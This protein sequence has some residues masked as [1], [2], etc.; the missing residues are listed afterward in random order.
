MPWDFLELQL[1]PRPQK[2]FPMEEMAASENRLESYSCW[3]PSASQSHPSLNSVQ[4]FLSLNSVT[5]PNSSP[6]GMRAIAQQE[7]STPAWGNPGVWKYSLGRAG[8]EGREGPQQSIMPHSPPSKVAIFFRET[9]PCSLEISCISMRSSGHIWML[10]AL[11]GGE[12][13]MA[14]TTLSCARERARREVKDI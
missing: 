9:K 11:S 3:A 10:I 1:I 14:K 4:E 6:P 8:S 5:L 13:K 12:C 2:S 7:L